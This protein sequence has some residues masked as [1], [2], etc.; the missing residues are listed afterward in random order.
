MKDFR[1]KRYKILISDSVINVLSS[2]RLEQK[3]NYEVGGILLGQVKGNEIY[4]LRLSTPNKFDNASKYGFVREKN[5][6][7]I[8]IDYEFINSDKKTIYLGEWHT[9]PEDCPHPSTI[10]KK[11]IK[12]QFQKNTIN[13]PFL[14]LV[15]QGLKEL[16]VGAYSCDSGHLILV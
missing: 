4:V 12:E 16:Y 11:M 9:H 6:A 7:Q 14:L 15:I 10:D 5:L 1:G 3:D 13:E 8:I 2:Y